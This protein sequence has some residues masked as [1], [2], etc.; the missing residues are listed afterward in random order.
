[1]LEKMGDEKTK[2]K[3]QEVVQLDK[4]QSPG[5]GVCFSSVTSISSLHTKSLVMTTP[6]VCI[7]S[8][9]DS[10]FPLRSRRGRKLSFSLRV[11]VSTSTT[12]NFRRSKHILDKEDMFIK[13]STCGKNKRVMLDR[14]Y[15]GKIAV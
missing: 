12:C 9:F 3:I 2:E 8:L 5:K 1:M 13:D 6:S 7:T 10:C 4:K 14:S 11:S 15:M